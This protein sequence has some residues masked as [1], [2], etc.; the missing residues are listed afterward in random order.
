MHWGEKCGNINDHLKRTVD[1]IA[2]QS[3]VSSEGS[4]HAGPTDNTT[5]TLVVTNQKIGRAELNRL[6]VQVHTS[7]GRAIQ[8]FATVSDGDVLYAVTTDEVANPKLSAGQLSLIASEVAWDA[9]LASVPK[10]DPQVATTPIAI[11]PKTLDDF[12]GVYELGPGSRMT[13]SRSGNNL[14]ARWPND[15][16]TTAGAQPVLIPVGKDEFLDPGF[17]HNLIRFNRDNRGRVTGLTINPG[18][19]ALPGVKLNSR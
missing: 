16:A 13:I 8:P 10:A 15:A 7:M 6:A 4:S 9:V 3:R 14:T 2:G 1:S 18:N 12:T 17:A 5:I 19:W 11:D